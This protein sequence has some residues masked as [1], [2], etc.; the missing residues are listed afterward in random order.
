MK[1]ILVSIFILGAFFRFYGLNWDQNEH[2]HPDE[3]FLTMAAQGISWP[4][5]LRQFFDTPHSPAN[6]HNVGFP[7]YVYGTIPLF[8][9]KAASQLAAL[10]TYNGLTLV[11]RF[12][13][14]ALDT[15]VVL[16]VYLISRHLF[17]RLLPAF[18]SALI[19]ALSVLPVQLAHFFAV[20]TYLV[21]FL[22]LSFYLLLRLIS[23]KKPFP[24]AP[25]IFLG[26]SFGCALA[27]KITAVLFLPIIFLGL[28]MSLYQTRNFPGLFLLPS[29]FFL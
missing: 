29:F 17:R 10:D 3:R 24:I 6:P 16:L 7:F 18:F 9:V 25:A 5:S 21:F 19:Y 27:S 12:L 14:A 2:L 15:S 1:K 8:V 11:G 28:A 23:S 20:D 4:S 22:T 13:S 26:L